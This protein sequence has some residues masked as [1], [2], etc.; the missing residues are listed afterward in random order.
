[1]LFRSN[2]R[3]LWFQYYHFKAVE[4]SHIVPD[5]IKAIYLAIS[6]DNDNAIYE[7]PDTIEAALKI[8]YARK[9]P[10][11]SHF[12]AIQMPKISPTYQYLCEKYKRDD[13]SSL[14]SDLKLQHVFQ[15]SNLLEHCTSER[16]FYPEN[17]M[18][19]RIPNPDG[20]YTSFHDFSQKNVDTVY[21]QFKEG[22]Q[23]STFWRSWNMVLVLLVV[24]F[25][26]LL[27]WLNFTLRDILFVLITFG[28]LALFHS[29][30][31]RGV[32]SYAFGV[33]FFIVNIILWA[34]SIYFYL[35]KEV[36]VQ[37]FAK[38]FIPLSI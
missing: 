11:L 1:M 6:K 23:K 17:T 37:K 38:F 31:L 25:F 29:I 3:N 26:V 13:V 21:E 8:Y 19:D 12:L 9:N 24:P 28:L 33:Y 7:I 36:S 22:E 5:S 15:N 10:D 4:E 16:Y 18:I 27:F 32:S 20:S 30:L 14:S 2:E 35:V 34:I